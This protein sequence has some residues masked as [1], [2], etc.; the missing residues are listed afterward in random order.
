MNANLVTESST[1]FLRKRSFPNLHIADPCTLIRMLSIKMTLVSSLV[2]RSRK[3]KKNIDKC[4]ILYNGG[5][6]LPIG[7]PSSRL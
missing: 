4:R 3:S 2:P 6:K 5:K 1:K 7:G